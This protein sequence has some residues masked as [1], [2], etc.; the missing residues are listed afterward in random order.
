MRIR[1][2]VPTSRCPLRQ[3]GR[4]HW[5]FGVL[6][7]AVAAAIHGAAWW[8]QQRPVPE[9]A[10]PR[11]GGGP[12]RFGS[13]SVQPVSAEAVQRGDVRVLVQAIGTMSARSTAVVRA[14][15]SGELLALR[16]SE[17]DE[18]RAGQ[19]LAEIDP[20]SYQ[21]TLAQAE[22]TLR[23]DQA[24]LRNAQLDLQRYQ[25]L[26][27]KDS[28]AS[29]QVDTQAALVRQLEGTVAAG[30]AQVDA[31][32]LQLGHT[33][34]TAPFAGRLGLRQADRG[35]IVGP[36]DANGIV[37]IN[38]VRPIDAAFSVPEVHVPLMRRRLATGAELPVELWDREG[39]RALARGRVVALDNAIDPAT[40]SI[41]VKAAFT[42]E[43]GT[44]YPNQFVNVRLQ[45]DL[46][47]GVLTVPTTALQNQ[48]VYVVGEDGTVAQ[49]R[50]RVGVTDGDR[51]SVEGD[52]REGDMVV[53]DGLDRLRDG[54]RVAVI[55]TGAARRADQAGQDQAARRRA[56]LASL[57]PEERARLEKMTP[58]E[59][60]AFLRERRAQAAASA[61]AGLPASS[62]AGS[63]SAPASGTAPAAPAAGRAVGGASAAAPGALPAPPA[64]P[65]RPADAA[66]APAEPGRNIPPQVRALF[67]Q[68]SPDERARVMALPPEERRAYIR[69]RLQAAPASR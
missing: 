52:L 6:L 24:L 32:R 31:A 38:Q 3:S 2:S 44:L 19:V 27:A 17:G 68:M 66:A 25:E 5:F 53:T 62:P 8:Y 13:G 18:V 41:R 7:L 55:D 50:V 4:G 39:R 23:R 43:D 33:Q 12:G 45:V 46:L 22:G 26:L 21:A 67:E 65:A 36:G 51:V 61:P 29:Q 9:A 40:G 58:E 34:V 63:A 57:S 48:F 56:L 42:N 49:R 69:E 30:Q 14:K 64:P 28:I 11:P 1:P 20:R 59:R 10:A 35:N 60:R 16:F 54:S 15:V 37:S 47:A